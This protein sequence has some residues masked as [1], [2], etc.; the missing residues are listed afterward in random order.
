MS[1]DG[2]E[3]VS[4]AEDVGITD[5]VIRVVTAPLLAVAAGL[6]GLV[7][8]AFDSIGEVVSALSDVRD[9]IAAIV[10]DGP[11]QII[12]EGASVTSSELSEF[13]VAAFVVGIGVVALGWVVWTSI[14]PDIPLLDNLLPWR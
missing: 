2:Q 3:F 12:L 1:A 4:D 14:D 10:V 11:S 9:F 8:V 5:A 13:G 7:T 6:S